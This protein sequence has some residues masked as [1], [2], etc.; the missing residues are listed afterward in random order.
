MSATKV[1]KQDPVK[2]PMT[3][4]FMWMMDEKAKG[5]QIKPKDGGKLWA[6]LPADKKKVWTDKYTK[7]KAEYD[8]YMIEVE[9]IEKKA[10]GPVTEFSLGRV[11]AVLTSVPDTKQMDSKI[12]KGVAKF[13]E[14]YYQDFAKMLIDFAK[15]DESRSAN[16]DFVDRAIS[17]N[18]KFA[19]IIRIFFY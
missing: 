18:P 10:E 3:A 2:K 13:L 15:T 5:N 16:L 14:N 11:R 8:K 6:E 7:E 17:Q 12:Y 9:G 19:K 4:Y 1:A